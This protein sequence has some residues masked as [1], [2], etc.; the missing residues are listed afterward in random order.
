MKELLAA[1]KAFQAGKKQKA[2]RH[3]QAVESTVE[4]MLV[5]AGGKLSG[6]AVYH[7]GMF[8]H[9]L[10]SLGEH[11]R[12]LEVCRR[13]Q[14][15]SD[16]WEL[17][18]QAGVASFNLDRFLQA[19]S[20]W[21]KIGHVPHVSHMQFM[22]RLVEQGTVPPFQL[23]YDLPD[24]QVVQQKLDRETAANAKKLRSGLVMMVMLE[25]VLD[26]TVPEEAADLIYPLI[27]GTGKWGRDL[28]FGLMSCGA[29]SQ[30]VRVGVGLAMTSA[31]HI[32]L[33]DVMDE[34]GEFTEKGG[35][36][37][38]PVGI[39]RDTLVY[40]PVITRPLR[41]LRK[42]YNKLGIELDT[43]YMDY[44]G[45]QCP[46]CGGKIRVRRGVVE[47]ASSMSSFLLLEQKKAVAYCLCKKC[48]RQIARPFGREDLVEITEERIVDKLPDL[49]RKV[50]RTREV[51]EEEKRILLKLHG[52]EE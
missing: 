5:A 30:V 7:L 21:S 22:A 48:A 26:A 23:E 35:R 12:V 24:P 36:E 52:E 45:E 14:K 51:I 27:A 2:R 40:E 9:T 8:L 20:Y 11:K 3:L 39:E 15:L 18:Y 13:W 1:L 25:M 16:D 10:G 38:K 47:D 19:A 50:E 49:E 44:F 4:N 33:E 6:E 42:R 29:V 28:G 37:E 34:G 31:G 17:H 43:R 41:L 32:V 46:R